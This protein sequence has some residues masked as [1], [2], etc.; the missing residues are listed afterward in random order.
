MLGEGPKAPVANSGMTPMMLAP[1]DL[2]WIRND[3][4]EFSEHGK[5]S[6]AWVSGSSLY[7]NMESFGGGPGSVPYLV[8]ESLRG[9]HDVESNS[10]LYSVV[11]KRLFVSYSAVADA[12]SHNPD[13]MVVVINPFWDLHSR[14]TFSGRRSIFTQ[15][16]GQW[17]NRDEWIW[18][19]TLVEPWQHLNQIV[20]SKFSLFSDRRHWFAMLQSGISEYFGVNIRPQKTKLRK[21][22]QAGQIAVNQP[23]QFW[24][25]QEDYQGDVKRMAPTG[26]VLYG[27]WQIVAIRQADSG[28]NSWA[29]EIL[30]KMVNKISNS[31]V[32]TLIYV[33]PILPTG[34]GKEIQAGRARVAAVMQSLGDQYGGN[35]LRVVTDFPDAVTESLVFRDA[36]HLTD[37]GLLPQYIAD[38]LND[39]VENP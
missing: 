37:A 32:P 11:G 21:R 34:G 35:T 26:R 1:Y 8:K 39:M 22:G 2:K 25:L 13:T 27:M 4:G 17:W 28:E 30:E 6:V 14:A 3:I 16:A 5:T 10:Y 19:F 24:A 29:R 33:A 31:G 38:T 9:A 36:I 7:M 15:T 23:F 18:Q 20:G 12:L